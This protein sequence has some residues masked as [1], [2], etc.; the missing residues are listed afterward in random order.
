[1]PP[2]QYTGKQLIFKNIDDDMKAVWNK[3]SIIAYQNSD[4]QP[5]HWKQQYF[6]DRALSLAQWELDG[7]DP[8]K[9]PDWLPQYLKDFLATVELDKG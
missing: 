8:A 9:A 2:I 4:I 6:K 3:A 1:M 7:F 5:M